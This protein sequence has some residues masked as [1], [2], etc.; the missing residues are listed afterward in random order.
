MNILRRQFL[1]QLTALSTTASMSSL[2]LMNA[3][4]QA[5]PGEDYKAL[6]CVFLF[7]GNDGNNTIIPV[8]ASEYAAYAGARGAQA[9]G[10]VAIPQ[11]ELVALTPATGS[12]RFGLNPALA[13][14][15]ALW[16]DGALAALFNVGTLVEPITK[17]QYLSGPKPESLFSH[18]DQQSQWQASL[19][20]APS[21][22]GW[23]GRLA[24]RLASTNTTAQIPLLISVAG[25]NLF[26]TG[27]TSQPLA[28]PASGNFALAGFNNSPAAQARLA[29][30]QQIITDPTASGNIALAT[31]K[32][33]QQAIAHSTVIGPILKSTTSAIQPLF[34]TQTSGI[35][36]QLLQV[37]KVIEA[38]VSLGV[39]RQIFFVSLGGFDTHSGQIATQTKL[40]SELGGALKTFYAATQQLHVA[41]QVTTFTLSDFGR[42]LKPS[43]GGGSDHAWGNH[44][45]IL[46]G[47]VKGRQTYGTFPTHAL[48][49]PDD[50]SK[51]GRWL[52]TTSVDQYAATLAT[53]FGL[54]P[55]DLS[56][57]LP[58]IGRFDAT[59]PNFMT[60]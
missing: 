10:G 18:S 46:G 15:Q 35:A 54:P 43:S 1:T 4:A 51:E 21:R 47:A 26:A 53:W 23:G 50:V 3:L 8:E 57:V 60:I 2:S 39:K 36:K 25:N 34:D 19:S 11:A 41:N 55:E 14:L 13:D 32:Q 52:P 17:A 28:V 37:A 38:R 49:G 6:V 16:N 33:F 9:D 44:H 59:K 27:E 29:A 40:L 48:D 45:F 22:T 24:D 31:G 7:G 20:S 5:A 58:N 12:V 30:L 42:T 56:L